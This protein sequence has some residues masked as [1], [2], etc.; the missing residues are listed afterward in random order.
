MMPGDK[1]LAASRDLGAA[2]MMLSQVSTKTRRLFFK[3]SIAWSALTPLVA[4]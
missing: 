3:H 4:T 1:I 2:A